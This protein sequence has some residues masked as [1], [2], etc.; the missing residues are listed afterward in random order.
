M[1]EF[2]STVIFGL[3]ICLPSIYAM[4]LKTELNITNNKLD[5]YRQ[6]CLTLNKGKEKVFKDLKTP[7]TIIK[8][9]FFE[10]EKLLD[11]ENAKI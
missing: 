5:Y 3:I 9:D 10:N 2:T 8:Y 11:A 4:V 7:K 1:I 6:K